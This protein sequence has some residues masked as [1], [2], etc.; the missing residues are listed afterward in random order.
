MSLFEVRDHDREIYREEIAPWLPDRLL[1]AHVHAWQRAHCPSF[2]HAARLVTWPARVAAENPFEDLEES[3]RLFFPGKKVV[4]LVFSMV[5]QPSDD[6]EAGNA[7]V[8]A[9]ARK[10]R[11]PALLFA[12]PCWGGAELE[13]RIREGGFLG[14]KVYLSLSHPA[15]PQREVR[16]HDFLPPHQLDVMD[17]LGG[18]VM[19][20]IPRDGRLRDPL[21]LAQMIEIEERWP[22]VKLI[23]AHVGRAYV[24]ED[25]G[26]AFEKL[27]TTKKMVFDLSANTCREVFVAL[28]RAVGPER[29]LFASDL[30]ITRMRMRRLAENGRYV[31]LVKK[32][33]YGDV[34]GD[35][36]MREIE[37]PEAERLTFFLYEELCQFL[38]AAREVGLSKGQ[39]A[40][41]FYANA[42]RLIRE[43][44]GRGLDL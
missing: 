10:R 23:I 34:S 28:L 30:P 13:R 41:V 31:N 32:G 22:N 37:G 11:W 5:V 6:H 1:D 38:A 14:L 21:N 7:Y 24:P 39:I 3:Y 17:R 16:I 35:P 44:G 40:P 33:A 12:L 20:H 36:N 42:V 4:P 15:I 19:L 8:S 26:D 2:G 18:I 27:S 25:V 9:E 43:A 29:V